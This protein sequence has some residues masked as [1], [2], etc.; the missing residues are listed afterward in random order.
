MSVCSLLKWR[1]LKFTPIK[2]N[3]IIIPCK[4]LKATYEAKRQLTKSVES[5]L[6]SKEEKE[7]RSDTKKDRIITKER[8]RS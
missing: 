8:K 1:E 4:A 2:A 3:I 5:I 6:A 7:D